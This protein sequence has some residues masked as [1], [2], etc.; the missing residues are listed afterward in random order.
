M[1]FFRLRLLFTL[2]A[3]SSPW[4]MPA[5][6]W[7]QSNELTKLIEGAKR[8]KELVIYGSTDL[9]QSTIIND[10]F[11]EKYPFI[12][13]KL[14]RLTSDNLYP[15]VIA[16]HRSGKFLADLLQNNTLGMYFLRKGKFLAHY[17]SPEERFFPK[18]FKDPGYWVTSAMNLHVIGYNTRAVA[19]DKL[20]KTWEDLLNPE[21]KG[22]KIMLNPD[23]QW[24]AFILQ[25]MGKE[26]GL[27]YMRALAKQTPAV[28]REPRAMRAQLL[29]AGEGEMD[30]DSTYTVLVPLV[31]KGAPVDWTTLGPA[32]MNTVGYGLAVRAPHPNAAKLFIAYILSKEGQQVVL[33]FGRQS[34]RSDLAQEQ[35]A[36][37]NVQ[38]VPLDPSQGENMEFYARQAQEIFGK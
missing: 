38:M 27:N 5:G 10:K 31:K 1:K 12:E 17:V 16:E 8:E 6:A 7:A 33:S 28:R 35:S 26:K 13:V 30:L 36:L 11:H 3:L 23:E 24:F 22:G 21:W 29:I 9:R 37:K 19:R 25:I 14:N 2:I 34:A 18:E 15:R 4:L 20:P 32:L